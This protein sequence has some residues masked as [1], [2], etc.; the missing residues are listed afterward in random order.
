MNSD[1]RL[2]VHTDIIPI[3]VRIAIIQQKLDRVRE[4]R[5]L[6]IHAHAIRIAECTAYLE[7][8]ISQIEI[9]RREVGA[10]ECNKDKSPKAFWR[11][12]LR[13]FF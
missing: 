6:L 10:P 7:N 12:L 3:E 4:H 8:L 11:N 2:V 13:R 9:L 1:C 5:N